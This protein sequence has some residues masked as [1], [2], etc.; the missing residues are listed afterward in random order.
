MSVYVYSSL[1]RF[2]LV[3]THIHTRIN[4]SEKDVIGRIDPRREKMMIE[5]ARSNLF[6]W[7]EW[8]FFQQ[9]KIPMHNRSIMLARWKLRAEER[10]TF[11]EVNTKTYLLLLHL[12]YLFVRKKGKDCRLVENEAGLF[13]S[14]EKRTTVT[15][16]SQSTFL[17]FFSSR[18]FLFLLLVHLFVIHHVHYFK[19]NNHDSWPDLR[20]ICKSSLSKWHSNIFLCFWRS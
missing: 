8:R 2:P 18:T 5:K 12:P 14:E 3:N 9:L 11:C 16:P 6:G 13:C 1:C 20:A 4:R 19:G 7:K 10:D 15:Q 17:I